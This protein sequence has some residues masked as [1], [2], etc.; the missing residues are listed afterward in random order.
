MAGEMLRAA[1]MNQRL[2]M[3]QVVIATKRLATQ[4]DND[5]FAIS[6]GHL[7]EIERRDMAPNIYRLYSLAKVYNLDLLQLLTWFGIPAIAPLS[8]P[9]PSAKTARVMFDFPNKV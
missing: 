2:T 4:L 9:G 7:S 3:R 6:L 5:E 8:Q 1:R